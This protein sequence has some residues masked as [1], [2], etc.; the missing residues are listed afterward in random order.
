[1]VSTLPPVHGL[2]QLS[3]SIL[4]LSQLSNS[5]LLL[6]WLSISI[7]LLSW[8]SSSILLLS[9]LSIS[10]LLLSWLS[11][12]IIILSQL[13][14]SNSNT[15]FPL[16]FLFPCIRS[17]FTKNIFGCCLLYIFILHASVEYE[18]I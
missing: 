16:T 14:N 2:Q 18:N 5:I 6:S 4:I 1:M 8:L 15:K 3:S 10:I 17:A 12:S 11:S 9:W 13:S 7:V